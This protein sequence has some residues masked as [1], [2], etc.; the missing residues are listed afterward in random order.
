MPAVAVMSLKMCKS[1]VT[2]AGAEWVEDSLLHAVTVTQKKAKVR[3][4][5]GW[6]LARCCAWRNTNRGWVE[7]GCDNDQDI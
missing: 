6:T 4:L 3:N 1:D 7:S 5:I 2:D